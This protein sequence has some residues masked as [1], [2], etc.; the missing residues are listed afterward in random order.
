MY[1]CCRIIVPGIPAFHVQAPTVVK[2]CCQFLS[3]SCCKHI[4]VIINSQ[5]NK[6]TL[7]EVKVIRKRSFICC[8]QVNI[9]DNGLHH[10]ARIIVAVKIDDKNRILS[11]NECQV[12][13][14]CVYSAVGDDINGK[15]Y[16]ISGRCGMIHFE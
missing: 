13:G 12:K 16:R 6:Y 3:L 2:V 10:C 9:G 15:E 14:C 4:V 7:V 11:Y 1:R 5:T 8:C